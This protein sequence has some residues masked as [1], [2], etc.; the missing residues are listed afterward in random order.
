MEQ[1]TFVLVP[2]D[3]GVAI[4]N[5][6]ASPKLQA[7]D[8]AAPARDGTAAIELFSDE[9]YQKLRNV[10]IDQNLPGIDIYIAWF[11]KVWNRERTCF[12]LDHMLCLYAELDSDI[13][14][15]LNCEKGKYLCRP[16]TAQALTIPDHASS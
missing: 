6:G 8:W 3:D 2:N 9:E 7:V 16:E 14:I 4:L 5:A 15:Y 13:V 10:L 1:I 11:H 12:S